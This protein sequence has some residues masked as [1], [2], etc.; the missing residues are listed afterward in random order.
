MILENRK[1]VLDS[2]MSQVDIVTGIF[3]LMNLKTLGFVF[4]VVM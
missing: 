2:F 4:I 3:R 1:A